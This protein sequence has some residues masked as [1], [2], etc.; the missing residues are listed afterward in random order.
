MRS[1]KFK[2]ISRF[3]FEKQHGFDVSEVDFDYDPNLKYSEV[4]KD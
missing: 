1:F 3:T 2:P 4:S